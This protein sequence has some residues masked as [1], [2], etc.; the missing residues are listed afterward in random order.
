MKHREWLLYVVL[1]HYS[2]YESNYKLNSQMKKTLYWKAY[3]I[4]NRCS[5]SFNKNGNKFS[6]VFTKTG[7]IG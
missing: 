5:Y 3:S 7:T 6:L 2:I 4:Q 1:T